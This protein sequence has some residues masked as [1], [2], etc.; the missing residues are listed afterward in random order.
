MLGS[1]SRLTGNAALKCVEYLSRTPEEKTAFAEAGALDTLAVMLFACQAKMRPEV[2]RAMESI[3]AHRPVAQ[4]FRKSRYKLAE[5][6]RY[7]ATLLQQKDKNSKL[8]AMSILLK[9]DEF[10]P[11]TGLKT[12]PD[13][14][15]IIPDVKRRKVS[16]LVVRC[17]EARHHLPRVTDPPPPPSH[18]TPSRRPPTTRGRQSLMRES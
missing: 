7:L 15:Q 5:L 11:L 2:L 13:V 12:D 3:V 6:S 8:L 18:R 10:G 1:G 16:R 9:L 14:A 17:G 4:E